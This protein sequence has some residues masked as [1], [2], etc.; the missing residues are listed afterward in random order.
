MND[1]V[2]QNYDSW[3]TLLSYITLVTTK[4]VN[5]VKLRTKLRMILLLSLATI[6]SDIVNDKNWTA[7]FIG[8]TAYLLPLLIVLKLHLSFIIPESIVAE[9]TPDPVM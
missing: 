8:Q 1:S 5:N 6:I 3:R 4:I 9:R 7:L 2:I